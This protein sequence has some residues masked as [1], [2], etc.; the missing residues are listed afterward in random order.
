MGKNRHRYGPRM[1]VGQQRPLADRKWKARG[2]A[3]S[4]TN[5]KKEC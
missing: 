4:A 5:V 2:L 3:A 1:Q